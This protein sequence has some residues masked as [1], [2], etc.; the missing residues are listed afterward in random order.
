MRGRH[1]RWAPLWL[2]ML[3]S[4]TLAVAA[5]A[6]PVTVRAAPHDGFGRIVFNWP[7]PVPYTA[8]SEGSRVVIRFGRPIEADLGAVI[9]V[10]GTYVRAG[11]VGADGRSVVLATVGNLTVRAFDLGSAVVLDLVEADAQPPAKAAGA[12]AA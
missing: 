1:N 5:R 3:M 11:D 10:L 9:R 12:P 7:T 4:L 6:E 8:E 2:G